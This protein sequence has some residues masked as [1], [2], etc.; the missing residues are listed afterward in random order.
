MRS[1]TRFGR[2]GFTRMQVVV[3]IAL[4]LAVIGLMLPTV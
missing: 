3:V 2:H 1:L 4:V